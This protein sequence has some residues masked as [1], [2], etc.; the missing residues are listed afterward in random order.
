MPTYLAMPQKEGQM[1]TS[2]RARHSLPLLVGCAA[3]ILLTTSLCVTAAF[4]VDSDNFIKQALLK[5]A[6]MGKLRRTVDHRSRV[7]GLRFDA[8]KR[9]KMP[10][11]DPI[12]TPPP[13]PTLSA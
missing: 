11:A 8:H 3:A 4:A 7:H 2:H 6:R 12:P 13:K 9:S 5:A 10:A 1:Q